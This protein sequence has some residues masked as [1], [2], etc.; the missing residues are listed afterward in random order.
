MKDLLDRYIRSPICS[1]GGIKTY[2][3]EYQKHFL[4][5]LPIMEMLVNTVGDKVPGLPCQRMFM[6]YRARDSIR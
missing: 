5:P 4:P 6:R 2:L 3:D 1:L